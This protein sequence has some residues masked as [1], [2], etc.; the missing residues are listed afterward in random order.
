MCGWLTGKTRGDEHFR[1]TGET[2]DEWCSRNTPIFEA[3][4]SVI[5]V[6][7]DIHEEPHKYEEYDGNDLQGRQEVL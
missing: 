2:I 7:P 6:V 5:T 1:K 4:G 3:D